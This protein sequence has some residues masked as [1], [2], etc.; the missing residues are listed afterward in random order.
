MEKYMSKYM[1]LDLETT[2]L[3]DDALIIELGFVPVNTKTKEIREN[4]SYHCYLKCPSFEEL[5]PNLN[6]FVKKHNKGLIEKAHK[7][8][9][10]K[11]QFLK[12]FDEYMNSP[13]I[14][15]F[16]GE[17]D[18]KIMGK[19]LTALDM[20]LLQRDFGRNDFL[21]KYFHHRV[22]DVSCSSSLA[23]DLK[24][25]PEGFESSHKLAKFFKLGEDVSHTAISDSIDVAKMYMGI[26]ELQEKR[27][28][29]VTA[30]VA[31]VFCFGWILSGIVNSL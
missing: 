4:L 1:S 2:G 26:V 25:L 9:I 10:S 6:D 27:K 19:S 22:Q 20:P 28:K 16:Y 12:E 14:K 8:G 21:R 18:I 23:V 11:E 30:L 31:S 15:E 7:E 13:K 29:F 24:L 17:E 5:E 3:E